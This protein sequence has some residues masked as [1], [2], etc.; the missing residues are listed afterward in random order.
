MEYMDMCFGPYGIY[1]YVCYYSHC[2][3]N[4][5]QESGALSSVCMLVG[6]LMIIFCSGILSFMECINMCVLGLMESINTCV[7]TCYYSHCCGNAVQE[8]GALPSVCMLVGWLVD[9]LLE[10]NVGLYGI[11]F[12][13]F[14][15][16]VAMVMLLKDFGPY[17]ILFMTV[18]VFYF[19]F[20][21]HS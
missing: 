11:M 20:R 14:V 8:F 12:M 21:S 18:R 6:S 5:V 10:I 16:S 3:G 7:V 13:T 4:A 1:V 19:R 15:I 9:H 17:G 2:C